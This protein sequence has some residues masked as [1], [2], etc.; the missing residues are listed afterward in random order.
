MTKEPKHCS[1]CGIEASASV[2]MI[3]GTEGYICEACVMLASQV[4][5]SWG[6]KKE[7]ADMQGPLPKPAE[8]KAMLDQY[9][10]GQD[11]AKEI[12]SVAV[13]N[14]YK[15]LKHVGSKTG[16]LGEADQ[17][18]EIGKSNILMIGPSG[19]G[20]TLLAST[21][22]KIVGVPFAVADATT[23]TQAGYV[24]DDV[25]NILVRL[26]DVADGQISRAEW[27][28]VYIDEVDKIARSPEQA[29]GTRDVS[30]EG[31]QQALLR[32]VE[33][34]QVKVPTKGRRKDHNGSDSVMVDTGNILFIAGGAFPGLEK[35]VEKRLQ[36]PKT[37][38][39][40]HAEVNNP[41]DKPSLEQMLNATQ[42]DDLKRFG[43]I[44]EFIGRFP[45]L[46]PLEPLDVDAL[47]QVLTEPK[48]ALVKQYQQLF[49]FDEVDLEFTQDAL[50]EIAEK[51][52]ARNTGARGLRG[53]ME[54]VLRKTMFELPSRTNVKRCIVNAEVIRGEGEIQVVERDGVAD[55]GDLKRLSGGE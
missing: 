3:A 43:L 21:L 13:Y 7:L 6:K 25:E 9:V 19:T 38:I 5:S 39:G 48:N 12:L 20:K 27:G 54:H 16:G 33:G 1:F 41:N 26:L 46:A 30:G 32:L 35:H 52:I 11:L 14:H 17:S 28:I 18:V 51:A 23:L 55:G 31:V 45:V 53:I 8:M 10:I 42:P 29:F 24:G 47:I 15:R 50:V 49:A 4:V 36:P 44:P 2:P 40:F 22:A 37:A 34:S